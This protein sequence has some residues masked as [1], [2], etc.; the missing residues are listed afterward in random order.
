MG[1]TDLG[2]KIVERSII[3]KIYLL[4]IGMCLDGECIYWPRLKY[5]GDLHVDL[6][7]R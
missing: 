1:R 5:N 6:E 3:L 7:E 2:N 4:E